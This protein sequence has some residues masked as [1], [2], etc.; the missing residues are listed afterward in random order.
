MFNRQPNYALITGPMN[1]YVI[2]LTL[3]HC[4]LM[5]SL[6]SRE[7]PTKIKF[8]STSIQLWHSW[9]RLLWAPSLSMCNST[10]FQKQELQRIVNKSE[11]KITFPPPHKLFLILIRQKIKQAIILR[12]LQLHIFNSL[13]LTSAGFSL[14]LTREGEIHFLKVKL[15][16]IRE[17]YYGNSQLLL[18]LQ[19]TAWKHLDQDYGESTRLIQEFP[20]F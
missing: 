19:K 4:R 8:I 13:K 17:F 2:V 3:P 12:S 9:L 18:F 11:W 16:V 7:E 15:D 10:A 1:K 20:K 6:Y 5:Q 14:L